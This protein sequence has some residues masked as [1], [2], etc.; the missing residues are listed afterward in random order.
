MESNKIYWADNL[1]ALATFSVIILHVA[2]DMLYQYGVIPN[3]N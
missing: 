2:A 1:R 3:S